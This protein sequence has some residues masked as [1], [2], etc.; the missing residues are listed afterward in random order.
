VL[1]SRQM[2]TKGPS[3][4][5]FARSVLSGL[6]LIGLWV[7]ASTASAQ[8]VRVAAWAVVVPLAVVQLVLG[9]R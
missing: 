3:W 8:W 2:G 6:V 4:S 7:V 5:V 9:Y 1:H